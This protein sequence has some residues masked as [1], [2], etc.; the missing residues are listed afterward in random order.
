MRH[1]AGETIGVVSILEDITDLKKAEEAVR[2]ANE[3]FV[4]LIKASPLPIISLD[5]QGAVATW[6][7][8]AERTF[9][10]REP[11]VLGKPLP[12]IRE[13]D[14]DHFRVMF[15]EHMAGKHIVG[16]E[17][18]CLKKDGSLADVK[19]STSPLHDAAGKIVGSVG[20]LEDITALKKTEQ[21]LRKSEEQ[22]RQSQKMEAVGRLAGGVAHDFNNILTAISGYSEL[23]L[24]N[25][26]DQNPLSQDVQEIQR[27]ADRAATLTQQLLAFSR[28]QVIR[29]QRLDL[30]EVVGN[31]DK[32]L[33]RIIRED[34]DLQTI[35]EP[36][37]G[38][39]I[40]DQ[41]QIEQVILNL[42]V[43]A[44]DAMPQGGKLT[45]ETANV[46]L[47]ENYVQR[48]AQARPG[49]YVLIAVSDTGI[50]LDREIQEH[51]FEPFFT[52]KKPGQG[53]GLG[54]SMVYAIVNQ[55]GGFI[56]V[57][58]EPGQGTAFKIYLP[59]LARTTVPAMAP[60]ISTAEKVA[61]ETILLAE[62]EELVRRVT[63][64]ILAGSGYTVLEAGNGPEA[65]KIS[66]QHQAPIHLLLTDV[67][68]PEMSGPQLAAALTHLRPETKVIFMSGHTENAIVHHGVLESGIAFLQ[69]PFRRETLLQKVRDVLGSTT[70]RNYSD[71][72]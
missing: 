22:L 1:D 37:L 19:V 25:L 53:T 23:L 47:D 69:K 28:K 16:L 66:A 8:A 11:E 6:N 45:L 31:M 43:N 55:G 26:G 12:F 29:P 65:L 36:G 70:A 63:S 39:V 59:R 71:I 33:R 18:E 68:M 5:T 58:S 10:W 7:E 27:A 57:Y 64:R 50:G 72:D 42:V 9:G 54:L 52:T 32:M 40:A 62:D 61:S 17:W 4:N 60:L 2:I 30:N 49:P 44:R 46:D 67:L 51:L 56:G 48:H 14:L 35:L 34:I 15:R 13:E 3:R 38:V 24:Q 41:G 20:I 21:A